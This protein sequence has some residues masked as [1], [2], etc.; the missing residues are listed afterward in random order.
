MTVR[1]SVEQLK[2]M[3]LA[4]AQ[5][6]I[7]DELPQKSKSHSPKKIK[8]LPS[9]LENSFCFQL[10][11]ANLP[12]PT[13]EL[14]FHPERRW[15]FDFAFEEYQVAVELE[16]GTYLHG[17]VTQGKKQ[18]SRHLTPTGFYADCQKYA[19]AGI[20]GWLV[21]RADAKMIKNGEALTL[22][23]RAIEARSKKKPQ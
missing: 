11:Q 15:R 6:I 22:T 12:K 16:G 9:N 21:I 19:E 7:K 17:K 5:H 1:L 14:Q 13:R 4:G 20:L 23:K 18:K 2:A 10:S 8:R 3:H